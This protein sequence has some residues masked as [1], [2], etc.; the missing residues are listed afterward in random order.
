M[1][2]RKSTE[3]AKDLTVTK[4]AR[5]LPTQLILATIIELSEMK[6]CH[7]RNIFI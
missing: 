7:A 2:L 5:S 4:H 3:Q 6:T 1:F